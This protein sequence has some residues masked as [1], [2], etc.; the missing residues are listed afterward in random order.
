MKVRA[1]LLLAAG[2][3]LC[4]GPSGL[5]ADGVTVALYPVAQTVAPGAEFD[6]FIQCTAAGA[7][8]NAF[9]AIVGWDPAAL[10][11]IPLSPVSVQEGSY[12]TGACGNTFHV[13]CHGASADTI[14]EVLLCG[15]VSLPGPGQLYR[16]RF[17]A[18][19]T[20]QRTLMRLRS[21]QFYDAGMYVKPAHTADSWVGIG[22]SPTGVG[23]PAVPGLTLDVM[24]NPSRGPLVLTLGADRAGPQQV[25]VRD[26]Q[27]R[28]VRRV[29]GGW[30]PAGPHVAAWDGRDEGGERVPPGIYFV[31]FELAG[32]CATRRVAL[33]P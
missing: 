28:M 29:A 13:F 11:N 25:I 31:T 27:G 5:W 26:L 33:L 24:P 4:S 18:S 21:I 9:D 10:T 22:M 8:F 15:G 23:D 32:R 17:R 7:S 14:T 6:I 30:C 16:L 19:N 20:P 12:M 1:A 2:V 3:L